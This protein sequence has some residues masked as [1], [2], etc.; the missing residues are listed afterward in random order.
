MSKKQMLS[1]VMSQKT[2]M[3]DKTK[4]EEDPNSRTPFERTN[5]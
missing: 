5:E 2:E 4:A 1:C 3:G